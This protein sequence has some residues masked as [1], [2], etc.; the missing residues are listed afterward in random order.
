MRGGRRNQWGLGAAGSAPAR[1][2]GGQEFE[3]PR[4]HLGPLAH[5][6]ERSPRT[7][8][9]SGS[10]P[11]RSTSGRSAVGSAPGLGP[12]GRRFETGHPDDGVWLSLVEHPADNRKVRGST[13]LPP[14]WP[15]DEGT[16][17]WVGRRSGLRPGVLRGTSGGHHDGVAQS[18]ERLAHNQVVAGSIPAAVTGNG[19]PAGGLRLMVPRSPRAMPC[20]LA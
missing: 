7:G 2:A 3:S 17:G 6:V 4:F 5:L 14:T 10:S 8:E 20:G 12:G 16:T 1:H 13:P 19:A 9:A 15:S 18:A 11:E